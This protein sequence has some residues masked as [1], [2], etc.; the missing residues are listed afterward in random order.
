[1]LVGIGI[2]GVGYES[3]IRGC[4]KNIVFNAGLILYSLSSSFV[5]PLRLKTEEQ[6]L[7]RVRFCPSRGIDPVAVGVRHRI[8]QTVSTHFSKILYSSCD[9]G[10]CEVVLYSTIG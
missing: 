5:C 4:V 3:K 2:L 6:D 8:K 9:I 7:V 10:V 1:M